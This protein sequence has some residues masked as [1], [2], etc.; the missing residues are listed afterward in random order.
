MVALG[1]WLTRGGGGITPPPA[2][3]GV[4]WDTGVQWDTGINWS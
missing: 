4:T 3:S 2:P 1:F